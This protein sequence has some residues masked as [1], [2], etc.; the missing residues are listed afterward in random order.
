MG[1]KDLMFPEHQI[2]T[3]RNR[4]GAVERPVLP[5]AINSFSEHT[6]PARSSSLGQRS[7]TSTV[8]G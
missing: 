5:R 8:A 1:F 7:S 6:V 2:L 4:I 3:R